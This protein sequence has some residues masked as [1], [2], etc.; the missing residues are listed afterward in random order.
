[1]TKR[2]KT[3]RG[4]SPRKVNTKKIIQRFL[5]VCEGEK[6]EPNYF[7]GFRIPTTVIIDIKGLGF[8]P[9]KLVEEA[10]ELSR[11]EDYDQIWC[12]F[13]RDDWPPEDFNA[14]IEKAKKKKIRIGL[15][16]LIIR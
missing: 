16:Q 2:K 9:S 15:S 11:E 13:D 6:T 5:I 1:M 3:S 7:R 10:K 4:Y 8:N 14:A 12:V